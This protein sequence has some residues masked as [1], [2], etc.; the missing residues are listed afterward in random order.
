VGYDDIY[1]EGSAVL[2]WENAFVAYFHRST[3]S[4][5]ELTRWRSERSA[6]ADIS[7]SVVAEQNGSGDA[8]IARHA[9][10]GMS[11]GAWVERLTANGQVIWQQQISPLSLD[12]VWALVLSLDG[13]LYA[14]GTTLLSLAGPTFGNSDSFIFELDPSS[15]VPIWGS[16]FGSADAEWLSSLAIAP[17]G[18]LVV[19]GTAYDASHS[20][21]EEKIFGLH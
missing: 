16:Q 12:Y 13:R 19:A 3:D 2:D 7:T 17:S 4:F 21:P 9:S 14:A 5:I 20:T 6:Y 15:G 11:V 1:V 8:F 18:A 10:G